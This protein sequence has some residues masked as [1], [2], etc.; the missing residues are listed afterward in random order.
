MKQSPLAQQYPNVDWA[1]LFTKLGDLLRKDYDWT[2]DVG[3]IK[4]PMMIV[5]ADAYAV[6]T[7]HIAEFWSV[8]GGGKKDAGIDGS[9]RPADQLAILPGLTHYNI[10][11]SPALVQVVTPFLGTPI[12]SA[13]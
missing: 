2:K 10:V 4:V 3:A 5:F 1:R 6:R 9:G 8:L 12:E 11:V 13:K 7:E